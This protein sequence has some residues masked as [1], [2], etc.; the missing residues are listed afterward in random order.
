[1]MLNLT[2]SLVWLACSD[3]ASDS[4]RSNDDAELD[5]HL[6][7]KWGL[8]VGYQ[9]NGETE[10]TVQSETRFEFR[11]QDDRLFGVGY[12]QRKNVLGKAA[13]ALFVL[14]K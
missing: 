13:G 1:M 9:W 2:F 7:R 6:S 4:R 14:I 10:E 8:N 11:P 5:L 3:M 12:R